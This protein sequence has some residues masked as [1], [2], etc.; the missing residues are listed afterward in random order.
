M[1]LYDLAVIPHLVLRISR[2]NPPLKSCF[3]NVTIFIA[4]AVDGVQS[5]FLF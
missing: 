1:V 5:I 4:P 3:L 2:A